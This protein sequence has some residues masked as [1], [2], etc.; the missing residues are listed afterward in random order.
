[1]VGPNGVGKT[2]LLRLILGLERPDAGTIEVGPSVKITFIDQSRDDLNPEKTV[3][4]EI[5]EGRDVILVGD[6]EYHIREY[7]SQFQFKGGQQQTL[8]GKLSGGE[9]NRLLLAKTLRRGANLLLL[10]EPT[11]DLDLA[12]LRVLEVTPE[13]A[14]P[15]PS[16]AE[17]LPPSRRRR[18]PRRRLMGPGA[19]SVAIHAIVLVF[20]RW[21][22]LL[23]GGPPPDDAA[24]ALRPEDLVVVPLDGEAITVADVPDR[25]ISHLRPSV[26]TPHHLALYRGDPSIGSVIHTHSNYATAW[27]AA[28]RAIPCGLTA[29]ADEFGGEVPCAPYAPNEGD[30]IGDAMLAHRT[31]AP[32]ILLANH[33]VFTFDATPDKALKAAVMVEDAAKTMWLAEQLDGV[34]PL[35]AEEIDR[36]WD[37]YHSTY[38]QDT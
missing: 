24:V 1:M 23:P 2:T 4:E 19:V 3:Y 18:T 12:T 21:M 29:L 38:G 14:A 5:S 27:A 15:E 26:D 28:G 30:A 35:P 32:A 11:N 13:R 10:D 6:R 25:I 33:G 17:V 8:V 34:T 22:V 36:W 9:R 31:R 20:L 16:S 7:L 37:R